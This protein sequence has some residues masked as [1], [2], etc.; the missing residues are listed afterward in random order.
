[1]PTQNNLEGNWGLLESHAMTSSVK[2]FA[3]NSFNRDYSMLFE[4][5]EPIMP[6]GD[7][8]SWDEIS[9][10]RGLAPLE[11]PDSPSKSRDLRSRVARSAVM[12]DV[13]EHFD[14][15]ARYLHMIR[16]HGSDSA[17][18]ESKISTELEAS[19]IRVA[20]TKEFMAAQACING[21][22]NLANV[23]NSNLNGTLAYPI[24]TGSAAGAWSTISTLIRSSEIPTLRDTYVKGAGFHAGR[25]IAS[26]EVEGY[27]TSNTEIKDYAVES[28]GGQILQNSFVEGTGINLGGLGW[29]FTHGHYAL[30][31]TPTTTV[32]HQSAAA[33]GDADKIVVLPGAGMDRSVFAH[34]EGRCFI[35]AGPVYS[36]ASG[37]N[38]MLREVRGF[39]AYAELISNPI[40]IRVYVGWKGL[41]ILKMPN[42]V[43]AFDTTP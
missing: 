30:D 20:N 10:G 42:A 5:G 15:S 36:E 17:S 34:A 31:A 28:L 7:S 35:P 1:M 23:P 39:Y 27:L 14:L 12:V 6:M 11:G 33:A 2:R 4:A 37:A 9:M 43:L 32:D 18:V 13:K 24:A 8:A 25:V 19:A 26:K 41:Y 22:V 40:G 29:K 21:T 38:A 16:D 3:D